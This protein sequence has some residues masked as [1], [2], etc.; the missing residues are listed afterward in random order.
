LPDTIDARIEARALLFERGCRELGIDLTGDYRCDEPGAAKLLGVP[1]ETMRN[2]RL[3]GGK[4]PDWF[5]VA[6]EATY[7]LRELSRF[8]EQRWKTTP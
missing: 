3:K 6:R 4:G 8:V 5:I 2:W 1:L 7:C